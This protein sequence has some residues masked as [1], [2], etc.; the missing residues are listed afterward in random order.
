MSVLDIVHYG[1]PVLR[2]VCKPVNKFDNINNIINDM[3]ESMYEA[4]GIGLAANQVGIDMD[5]FIIDIS[6][7]DE[8]DDTHIFINSKII[9][10][11]NEKDIFQEGCL[12]L[13]GIALDILRPKKI[14][15]KYQTPDKI[16]HENKFEGLLGRAIQ[17]EI[18]HLNGVF[19]VDRVT[20]LERIKYKAE[21]KSLEKESKDKMGKVTEKKG[22]LL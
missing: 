11:E 18:D 12:S 21:L 19:I 15:L 16:W 10:F 6:H 9:A 14:I 22:F 13:P 1:N 20:E 17:H 3:F 8:T 4:D 7:T 5:I 2:K